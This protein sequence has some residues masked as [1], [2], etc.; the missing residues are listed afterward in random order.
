MRCEDTDANGFLQERRSIRQISRQQGALLQLALA[1]CH[2]SECGLVRD[3]CTT[4]LKTTLH[5]SFAERGSLHWLP[6][7]EPLQ[8]RGPGS[9]LNIATI[10]TWQ[11]AET[12]RDD[13]GRTTRF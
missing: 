8:F 4:P 12:N 3:E 9:P 11:C 2:A 1:L 6:G 5:D 7:N 13:V 10:I